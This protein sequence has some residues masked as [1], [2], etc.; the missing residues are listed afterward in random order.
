MSHS[1]RPLAVVL[2]VIT[3]ALLLSAGGERRASAADPVRVL[4]L[5]DSISAT[6]VW[7]QELGRLLDVGGVPREIHTVAAAGAS[8]WQLAGQT[9]YALETY[10]PDL[11]VIECGTN[12]DP[13]DSVYGESRTGWSFRVMVEAVH[14]F[15][16]TQPIPIVPTLIQ[17]SDPSNAPRWLWESNEP[18]TND[19]LWTNMRYYRPPATSAPWFAG[20]ADLQRIPS[21]ATYLDG[22]GIH[23]TPA[24]HRIIGRIVYDEAAARM[25]WPASG[26]PPPCGLDGHRPGTA[27]PSVARC[28]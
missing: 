5:G 23:P 2:A 22:T 19:V 17:Y 3:L 13:S 25:G 21:N 28:P 12:D 24:G 27:P 16:P 11:V 10:Q 8:C 1:R 18:R 7:Q 15:R 20:I 9:R 6:E 26:E 14:Q 4:V